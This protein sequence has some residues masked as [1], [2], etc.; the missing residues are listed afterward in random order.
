M[1]KFVYSAEIAVLEEC[2]HPTVMKDMCAECG[3]DL[4]TD[5]NAKL[6]VAV[7]PMVH[8][9][10][11]LKVRKYFHCKIIQRSYKYFFAKFVYKNDYRMKDMKLL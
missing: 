5:E 3:T 2:R 6:D 1:N 4:R 7:V 11:E 9:V 8:S 10:P